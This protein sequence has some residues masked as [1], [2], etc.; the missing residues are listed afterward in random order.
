MKY[1]PICYKNSSALYLKKNLLSLQLLYVIFLAGVVIFT[2]KPMR[3]MIKFSTMLIAK[4]QSFR[5]ATVPNKN[6]AQKQ[7]CQFKSN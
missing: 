6:V 1:T 7:V 4:K 3:N 5:I 2:S